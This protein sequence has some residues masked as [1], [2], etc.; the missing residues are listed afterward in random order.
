MGNHRILT[1]IA[2]K[3]AI[4]D[5]YQDPYQKAFFLIHISNHSAL[6]GSKCGD[7]GSPPL[8]VRLL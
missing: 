4:Q 6:S 7:F 3:K 1:Q 8:P 2:S 5:P